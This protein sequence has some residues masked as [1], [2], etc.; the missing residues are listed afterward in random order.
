M[1]VPFSVQLLVVAVGHRL[2]GA[3]GQLTGSPFPDARSRV[4]DEPDY[5]DDWS[6]LVITVLGWPPKRGIDLRGGVILV[7]EVDQEK[8]TDEDVDMDKLVAA[9]SRRVNPGGQKEVTV[10]TFGTEQV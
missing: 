7:Y 3:S 6:R 8:K 10:R 1:V 4:E 2:L 9:V 5:V